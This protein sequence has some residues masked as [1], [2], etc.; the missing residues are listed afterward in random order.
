MRWHLKGTRARLFLA[1]LLVWP[2]LHIGLSRA[3][4]FSPWRFG[5]WGMYAT[6]YPSPSQKP[7]HLVLRFE[8]DAEPAREPLRV[9]HEGRDVTALLAGLH[10]LSLYAAGNGL[11]D[12]T[13]RSPRAIARLAER[14]MALR[15]LDLQ[16]E[17]LRLA[18]LIAE[19]VP[20]SEVGAYSTLFALGER[21]ANLITA[22]YGVEYTFYGVSR[23]AVHQG[24]HELDPNGLLV[25]DQT[26]SPWL[27][28]PI[29]TLL[30]AGSIPASP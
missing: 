8:G 13:L 18:E 6:P 27:S 20:A 11:S 10:G 4:H 5:G 29:P 30:N 22:Q 9:W 24:Q 26:C 17:L 14:L 28:Q 16:P 21:K 12:I 1:I 23:G 2:L 3:G 19:L 25:E 15:Q 7:V